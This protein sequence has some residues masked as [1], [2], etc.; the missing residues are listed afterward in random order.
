MVHWSGGVAEAKRHDA[1][2][3]RSAAGLEGGAFTVLG[4]NLDLVEARP[5]V[6]L[7]EH[8]RTSHGI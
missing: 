8:A 6:H 7:G 2:L 1:E 3:E 5:E 4:D